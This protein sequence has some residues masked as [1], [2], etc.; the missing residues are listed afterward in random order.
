MFL[1]GVKL[2]EEKKSVIRSSS[3]TQ[4]FIDISN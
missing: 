3:K 1:S 4:F 2:N